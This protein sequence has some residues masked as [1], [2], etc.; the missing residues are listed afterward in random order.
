LSAYFLT[1]FAVDVVLFGISS[2]YSSSL[3]KP[4]SRKVR[5]MYVLALLSQKGGG[6]RTTLAVSLATAAEE[7]GL[8][9]LII[10]LDPQATACKWGDRRAV[11]APIV[12]D[13]QPARLANALAKAKE[14]GIKLALIATPPRSAE[15]ALAAA[16]LAHLIV[17]PIRAQMYDLETIPNTLE[18]ITT[19]SAGRAGPIPTVAVLNAVAARGN[20]H[21]QARDGLTGMGLAVCAATLGHRAAFGDAAALGLS[22]LEHDRTGQAA[23]EVRRVFQELSGLLQQARTAETPAPAK[24]RRTA[25]KAA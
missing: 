7:A 15:A 8:E 5:F 3:W 23:E 12:L 13:A 24:P 6:G 2:S 18:L 14:G 17:M 9:T 25:S 11:E 4:E 20:R 10:D 1:Y 21:E 16:K 22:V 19:A